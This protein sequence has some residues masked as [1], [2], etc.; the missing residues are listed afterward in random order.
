MTMPEELGMSIIHL[1]IAQE[2]VLVSSRPKCPLSNPGRDENFLYKGLHAHGHSLDK[3]ITDAQTHMS[4][5]LSFNR[6]RFP[7]PD[8]A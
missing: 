7:P 8:R 5:L 6:R 3:D 1:N 2:S 4:H